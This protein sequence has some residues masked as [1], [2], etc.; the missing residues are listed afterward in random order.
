VLYTFTGGN[1]GAYPNGIVG[2][3]KGNLYG[4]S[5]EGG[6]YG[7]GVVFKLEPTGVETVLHSFT[8]GTDGGSSEAGVLLHAG[9][10][11]G[12]TTNGGGT[13]PCVAGCGVVFELTLK[14]T[15]KVLHTF[16]GGSD[17]GWPQT[18]LVRD[19]EGNL[20]GTNAVGSSGYGTVFEITIA[21]AESTLH[22]FTGRPDGAPP[23]G[24][25]VMDKQGNLFGTTNG[26]GV[27][28]Y[29]AIYEIP[30]GGDQK[31]LYSFGGGSDGANPDSGLIL[32]AAGN[33]YGTTSVGGAFGAGT[34]FR[35]TP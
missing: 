5:Q 10:L 30:A 34:V 4:S 1:D 25:L 17:G 31:V 14:G 29:G 18:Q 15:D 32:D 33:L 27:F 35:L 2:D 3:S 22:S 26:G 23:N 28:G 8:G 20:Y 12:T 7:W 6:A 11:Y 13:F 16:T 9:K 21:G 19:A 24:R